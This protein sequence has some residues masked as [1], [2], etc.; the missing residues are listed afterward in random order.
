MPQHFINDI[1]YINTSCESTTLLPKECVCNQLNQ[2][3]AALL[4]I[5]HEDSQP[6]W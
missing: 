3:H 1:Y 6:L 2:N 4:L 5:I